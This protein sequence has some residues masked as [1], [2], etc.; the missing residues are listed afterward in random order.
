LLLYR[1]TNAFEIWNL[2]PTT[3]YN[4]KTG[5]YIQKSN[6]DIEMTFTVLGELF[7]LPLYKRSESIY[8]P[9]SY[10]GSAKAIKILHIWLKCIHCISLIKREPQVEYSSCSSVL[11]FSCV[12]KNHIV[13]PNI[14]LSSEFKPVSSQTYS[15]TKFS[16]MISPCMFLWADSS[17]SRY[18][19][20]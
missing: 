10:F 19:P 3:L 4:K 12:T 14:L 17:L 13:V 8:I 2:K 15:C 6:D 18:I 20:L 11:L 16:C 5:I 1:K 7:L 9:Y